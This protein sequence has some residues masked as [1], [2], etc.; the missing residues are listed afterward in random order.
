MSNIVFSLDVNIA[1]YVFPV[2]P[3]ICEIKIE[4]FLY[5]FSL[6][7]WITSQ[8]SFL[9]SDVFLLAFEAFFC[10][11][12]N[13]YMKRSKSALHIGDFEQPSM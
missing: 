6:Q 5:L 9:F 1:S 7:D 11:P 13:Y 3:F 8:Y 4:C 2:F 10:T 12:S